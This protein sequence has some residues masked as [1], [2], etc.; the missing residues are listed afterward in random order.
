[1]FPFYIIRNQV[2]VHILY[3]KTPALSMLSW[4]YVYNQK[5]SVEKSI[6]VFEV[7]GKG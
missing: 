1:M 3:I 7:H 5:L 2:K 6:L 4:K